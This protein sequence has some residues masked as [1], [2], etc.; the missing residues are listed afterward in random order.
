MKR[1][2]L[3][4]SLLLL[5]SLLVAEP[6]KA[7]AA[8]QTLKAG[9]YTASVGAI[10][11]AG[12]ADVIQETLGAAK[13]IEAAKVDAK[14]KTVQFTVKKDAAVPLAD[15]QTALKAASDQMGM[16]ADYRLSDV[17]AVKKG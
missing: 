1:S 8:A 2:P 5:P 11:C 15:L 3:T 14:T 6:A 10:P 4:L 7:P 9:T 13:G 12:C 17:K 16:G